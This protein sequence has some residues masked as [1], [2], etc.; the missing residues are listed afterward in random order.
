M[1]Y[2]FPSEKSASAVPVRQAVTTDLRASSRISE[3]TTSRASAWASALLRI[4]MGVGSA[5]HPDYDMAD[6][7]L[8]TF[9]NQDAEDMAEAAK[10]VSA[11]IQSYVIDGPDKAMNKFNQK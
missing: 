8:G 3:P 5:P 4:R 9:K 6:W 11:A 7:V 2:L 10:K 1:R